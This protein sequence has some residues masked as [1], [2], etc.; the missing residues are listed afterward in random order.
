VLIRTPKKDFEG[1]DLY[2]AIV[3]EAKEYDPTKLASR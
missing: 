2:D 3:E 1:Q